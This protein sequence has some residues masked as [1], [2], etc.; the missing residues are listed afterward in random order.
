MRT[1]S[2]SSPHARGTLGDVIQLAGGRR[3]IPAYAG[4]A[5]LSALRRSW[6]AV[7]PRIRGERERA[8]RNQVVKDG[9]SPHTRG[10][11]GLL[12]HVWRS[13]RFIPAYAGNAPTSRANLAA[14]PVHP[15]IRGERGTASMMY[16]DDDGSSPHTRGTRRI[17]LPGAREERF[18]PACAGNAQ[19]S[20]C[21]IS[22]DFGS[23]PHARGTHPPALQHPTSGRFI[24]AYAGNAAACSLMTGMSSVHPRIR[25]E[26][27]ASIA[28]ACTLGGSSPHT[29]GTHFQ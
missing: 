8:E 16:S 19:A 13:G 2:G 4:N 18:I 26:R 28:C 14:S 7:H 20:I 11:P 3:F 1:Y 27:L 10:T 5:A 21:C 23:S 29:R 15:R 6:A 12:H 17:D 24:P 22:S 25:G 9:S